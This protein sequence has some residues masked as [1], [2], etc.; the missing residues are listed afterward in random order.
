[1]TNINT[2]RYLPLLFLAYVAGCQTASQDWQATVA[3]QT[4]LVENQT[5][6]W[7]KAD[8]VGIASD[9]TEPV[10]VIIPKATVHS[11]NNLREDPQRIYIEAWKPLPHRP[12]DCLTF[13]VHLECWKVIKPTT[14][15]VIVTAKDF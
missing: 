1:M 9:K 4:V 14:T 7:I 5:P 3:K 15:K 6:L 10:V 8:G 2:I 11:H 12:F 13:S